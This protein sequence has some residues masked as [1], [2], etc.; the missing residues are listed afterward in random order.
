M[1][2]AVKPSLSHLA[3]IQIWR[4]FV[5]APRLEKEAS[6][7]RPAAMSKILNPMMKFSTGPVIALKTNL[8][9]RGI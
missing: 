4:H 5:H 6:A 3:L 9:L 8:G 1:L 2:Q 7:S